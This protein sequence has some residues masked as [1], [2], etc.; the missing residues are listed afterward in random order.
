MLPKRCIRIFTT[1]TLLLPSFLSSGQDAD[2]DVVKPVPY[3]S[4]AGNFVR[5]WSANAAITDPNILVGRPLRDV[6]QTTQYYD[7][8]GRPVQT[9]VRQGSLITNAVPVDAVVPVVYDEFGKEIRKYL[10]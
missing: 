6:K 5:S 8:L 4:A 9:V 3:T 7:G 10:P 1:L 2:P